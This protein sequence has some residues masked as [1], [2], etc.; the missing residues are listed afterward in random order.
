MEFLA[1]SRLCGAIKERLS[2]FLPTGSGQVG[3]MWSGRERSLEILCHGWDVNQ[4]HGKE[5]E[6]HSLPPLSDHVM[7]Y[8]T[9]K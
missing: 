6:I 4:G 7:T 1:A 2:H 3:R 5:S 8:N 9:A